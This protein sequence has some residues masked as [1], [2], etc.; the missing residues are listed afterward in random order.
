MPKRSPRWVA[1]FLVVGLVTGLTATAAWAAVVG[2]VTGLSATPGD[3][4]VTLSWTGAALNGNPVVTDYFVEY[5]ADNGVSWTQF[6]HNAS[7]ATAITVTGLLNATAYTFR[8]S[9]INSSGYGISTELAATPMPAYTKAH[10][11][12]YSA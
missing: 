8:V 9:P 4:Q 7:D 11:P 2:P 10:L 6:I 12:T 3:T 5:T 1:A